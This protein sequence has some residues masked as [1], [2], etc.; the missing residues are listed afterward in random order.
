MRT[1]V[2]VP[3]PHSRTEHDARAYVI[4]AL[5]GLD[6]SR[7]P[8]EATIYWGERVKS[9]DRVHAAAAERPVA[10]EVLK[11]LAEAMLAVAGGHHA[12]AVVALQIALKELD[13][14]VRG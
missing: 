8:R 11:H 9:F 6:N 3:E 1:V 5:A 12:V 10:T 14:K 4:S 7:T 2:E 13:E